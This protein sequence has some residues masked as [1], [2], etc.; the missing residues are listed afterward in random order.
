MVNENNES[1]ALDSVAS[2]I[3][4]GGYSAEIAVTR[5]NLM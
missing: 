4:S 1:V 2:G 3:R 5:P